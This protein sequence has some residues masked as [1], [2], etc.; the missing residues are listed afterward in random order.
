MPDKLHILII[1]DSSV[2]ELL[3]LRVLK[4]EGF[5]LT[6]A[7][8]DNAEDMDKALEQDWDLAISDCHMPCYSPEKALEQWRASHKDHPFI[9]VSGAIGEEEA[10]RLM[11]TGAN[12]FIKKDNLARLSPVITRE[13]NEFYERKA[14]RDAEKALVESTEHY[15]AIVDGIEQAGTGLMMLDQNQV[16]HFM[17]GVMIKWFG[18]QQSKSVKDAFDSRMIDEVLSPVNDIFSDNKLRQFNASFDN[19]TFYRIIATPVN[20][21][22]PHAKVLVM[23][24]DI[25]TIKKSQDQLAFLAHHDPLTGLPNRLLLLDRIQQSIT[26][27]KRHNN[28]IAVLFIDLD[29]FKNIN[30]SLGHVEGDHLLM[31]VAER[32]ST[33]IRKEDTLARLGGD[34]FI[35][36]MED[37]SSPEIVSNFAQKILAT[38]SDHFLLEDN[39]YHISASMGITLYPE[40]GDTPEALIKNAD[41][42]MYRAKVQGKDTYQFYTADMN[43]RTLEMLRLEN[44]LRKAVDKNQFE[45]FY[46]PQFDIKTQKLVGME[47]LIRWFHPEKGMV[48]PADFIPISEETG[49]IIPIGEW[50][51]RTAC[52]QLKEWQKN[53]NENLTIAI[54]LSPRQFG[55]HHLIPCIDDAIRQSG[56]AP[57]C[58]EVEITEGVLV[59]DVQAAIAILEKINSMGIKTS[60]DDFGTGYSS[61]AYLKRFPINKLKIDQS[62]VK[63]IQVD[64]NDE[65]IVTSVIRLGQSMGMQVIAEGVET[66]A[67]LQFLIK[68][69]CDEGQGYLLGRPVNAADFAEKF[70]K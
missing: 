44:D 31:L 38:F 29:R 68:Q 35:I 46:Q 22:E 17:N 37:V 12:D 43:A 11:K 70:L 56:L 16:I 58:L 15:R 42:A 25:S 59:E 9:L 54:N 34:E 40:D 65:A 2:D 52:F 60:I 48:S 51:I 23:M 49:S 20:T 5:E 30:E 36:L 53:N 32:L 62:F 55:H 3:L 27:A 24:Q 45:L 4:K 69:G 18:D 39:E 8:V 57:H 41:T 63:D 13:M 50:V 26:R 61:L 33:L 6:H 14:R 67:Q 1:D 47:A 7:R 21:I 28:S 64:S 66:E 19:E 10:A